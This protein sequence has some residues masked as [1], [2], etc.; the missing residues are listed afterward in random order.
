MGMFH[1]NA[2][3]PNEMGETCLATSD[4]SIINRLVLQH[5]S[6]VSNV[7]SDLM[8]VRGLSF[9]WCLLALY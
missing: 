8:I 9:S 1:T 3:S 4:S 6:V 5:G 2:L 7:A